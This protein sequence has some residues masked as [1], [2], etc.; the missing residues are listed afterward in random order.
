ME[1]SGACSRQIKN[2][3]AWRP[4]VQTFGLTELRLKDG[5]LVRLYHVRRGPADI[6]FD[7]ANIWVSNSGDN[8]VTK[9]SRDRR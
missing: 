6:L 3:A 9:I 8:V 4:M 2:R 5:S 1:L 7:G